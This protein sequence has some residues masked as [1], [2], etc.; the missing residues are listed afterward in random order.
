MLVTTN[1]VA[2]TA[3]AQAATF[4]GAG[5]SAMGGGSQVPPPVALIQNLGASVVWVSITLGA[6]VAAI[7][8]A[9]NTTL[10]VPLQPNQAV[11]LRAPWGPGG[12]EGSPGNPQTQGPP[13]STTLQINTISV[14]VS[15]NLSVTFGEGILNT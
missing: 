13:G 4:P 2:S 5:A 7:P 3:S 6:R 12:A 15:Q 14:G 10:E 11:T 1:G 9:G 8:A